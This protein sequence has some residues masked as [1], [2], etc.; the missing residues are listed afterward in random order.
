VAYEVDVRAVQGELEKLPSTM[1][2]SIELKLRSIARFAEL[3]P[4][5]DPTFLLLEGIDPA[6]VFRFE[7]YG[8]RL[9]YEVDIPGQVVRAL[10]LSRNAV[11]AAKT[12]AG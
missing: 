8:Y 12:K 10:R 7:I 6:T 9:S 3:T 2:L 5:P 11:K 4:P 1:R